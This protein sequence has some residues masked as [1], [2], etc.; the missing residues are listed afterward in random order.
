MNG[1]ASTSK[2]AGS[3]PAVAAQVIRTRQHATATY[4]KVQD[5]R[6]RPIRG[7]W[8]R[9]QRYYAQMTV[10]D[11]TTGKKQVR[12]VHLEGAS[13]PAQARVKFEELLVSRRKGSLTTLKRTPTFS[14]FADKYLEFYRQAKDA[15]R[16]STIET[17]GYAIDRWKAHL[18]NLRLNQI[19]RVH[20]DSFIAKRQSENKSAR[21][22]NLEVTIFRNVMKRAIDQK[23]IAQLPTENLRPLKSK[24]HKRQ[25]VLREQIDQMLALCQHS[26]CWDGNARRHTQRFG[27]HQLRRNPESFATACCRRLGRMDGGSAKSGRQ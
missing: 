18:G 12:R 15:K 20:V 6:K 26:L 16:A 13:T 2:A 22:V 23:L 19:K 7:L 8:V 17:E 14:E 1:D 24:P 3:I 4:Q 27:Q 11:P 10:E 21:T 5:E 25:L 9:N